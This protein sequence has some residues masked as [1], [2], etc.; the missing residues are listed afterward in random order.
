ML[1]TIEEPQTATERIARTIYYASRLAASP[2]IHNELPVFELL[3]QDIADA[4]EMDSDT[5][6]AFLRV[7]IYG[8]HK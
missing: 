4:L 7:A 2:H 8:P 3:A 6:A 1:E 5:E